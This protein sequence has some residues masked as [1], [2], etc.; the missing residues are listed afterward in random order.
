MP[1]GVG[2]LADLWKGGPL[3]GAVC[4]DEA[5]TC[6][7]PILGPALGALARRTQRW[8]CKR[9]KAVLN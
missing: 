5:P 6:L 9:T 1:A 3:A 2:G 4:V 7:A 8:R